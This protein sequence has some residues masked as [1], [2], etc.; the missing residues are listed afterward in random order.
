[1]ATS[2]SA[3]SP[4]ASAPATA[5]DPSTAR[6][7]IWRLQA[8]GWTALEAGNLVALALGLRPVSAG[9]SVREIE[10]LRFMRSLVRAGRIDT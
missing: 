10:H 8:A 1:M 6:T 5:D 2:T 9:W 4:P 7:L 3:T